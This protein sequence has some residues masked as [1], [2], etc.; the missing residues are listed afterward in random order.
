[1]IVR[2]HMIGFIGDSTCVPGGD[3][4]NTIETL[5][6]KCEKMHNYGMIYYG[7]QEEN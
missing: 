4:N 5:K 3:K 1:M 7:S 6:E 2:C